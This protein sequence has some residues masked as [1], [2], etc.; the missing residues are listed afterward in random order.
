MGIDLKT[1][2][3]V[4]CICALPCAFAQGLIVSDAWARATPAGVLTGAVYLTFSNTDSKPIQITE[5]ATSIAGIC[6]IHQS[7]EQDGMVKMRQITDLVIGAGESVKLQPGLKHIMLMQMRAPLRQ[8]SKFRLYITDNRQ[9]VISTE[10]LVGGY[11]QL[12]MPLRP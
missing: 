6:E 11:G 3:F 12:D 5:I 2:F 10:V 1:A 7:I 4:C 8:G 9:Q